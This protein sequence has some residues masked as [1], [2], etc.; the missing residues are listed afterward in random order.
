MGRKIHFLNKLRRN[1]VTFGLA[2]VWNEIHRPSPENGIVVE[3]P[4][5]KFVFEVIPEE[6]LNFIHKLITFNK[7][8]IRKK[9]DTFR[10]KKKEKKRESLD[11]L[12][13]SSSDQKSITYSKTSVSHGPFG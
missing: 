6:P 11:M 2:M 10:V 8:I 9:I 3:Y 7:G 13:T 5:M 4:I 12:Q 1:L